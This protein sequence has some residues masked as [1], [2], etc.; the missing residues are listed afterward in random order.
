MNHGVDFWYLAA[1]A[2]NHSKLLFTTIIAD[3]SEEDE[4]GEDIRERGLDEIEDELR[5]I[6]CHDSLQSS[7]LQLQNLR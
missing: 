3:D 2:E 4:S 5:F 1:S 6:S 7:C